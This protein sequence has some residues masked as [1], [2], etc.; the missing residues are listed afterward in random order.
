MIFRAFGFRIPTL[1]GGL[2]CRRH[3]FYK[4]IE[5]FT[6]SRLRLEQIQSTADAVDNILPMSALL[7]ADTTIAGGGH[8]EITIVV[9]MYSSSTQVIFPFL[10][11]TPTPPLCPLHPHVHIHCCHYGSNGF[12]LC[13]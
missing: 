5:L 11:V 6:L 13:H 8:S 12:L 4:G 9:I 3:V 10:S 1:T 7:F 2:S